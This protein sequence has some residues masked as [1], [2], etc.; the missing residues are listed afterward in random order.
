MSE[1]AI[2][3]LSGENNICSACASID[4]D[5]FIYHAKDVVGKSLA[6]LDKRF[7]TW[8]DPDCPFALLVHDFNGAVEMVGIKVDHVKKNSRCPCYKIFRKYKS[9]GPHTYLVYFLHSS[10]KRH[11]LRMTD[12]KVARP[13]LK[14]CRLYKVDRKPSP[15]YGDMASKISSSGTKS[16]F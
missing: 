11:D 6:E 13:Q 2:S 14:V 5:A 12:E 16:T 3:I 8:D 7:V 1:S 9:L 15:S 10:Q 4:F